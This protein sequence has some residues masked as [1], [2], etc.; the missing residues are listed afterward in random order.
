MTAVDQRLQPVL[1]LINAEDY[2]SAIADLDVLL[3]LPSPPTETVRLMALSGAL[4]DLKIALE[5]ARNKETTSAKYTSSVSALI[6]TLDRVRDTLSLRDLKGAESGLNKRLLDS[7]LLLAEYLW[8]RQ[9]YALLSRWLS[10]LRNTFP[11]HPRVA[12]ECA[13]Y[14]KLLADQ[15]EASTLLDQ[16]QDQLQVLNL[17]AARDLLDKVRK[18]DLRGRSL[19]AELVEALHRQQRGES[20][21][22]DVPLVREVLDLCRTSLV[23]RLAVLQDSVAERSRL[24]DL[25]RQ[26]EAQGNFAAARQYLTALHTGWPESGQA[27]DD[28]LK[29]LENRQMAAERDA[30]HVKHIKKQLAMAE[31]NGDFGPVEIYIASNPGKTDKG[32]QEIADLRSH[33]SRAK[34]TYE[35][36]RR[37]ER[38]GDRKR[39]AEELLAQ[40]RIGGDFQSLFAYLESEGQAE[41]PA[42]KRKLDQ[43]RHQAVLEQQNIQDKLRA[44]KERQEAE[45]WAAE[46]RG[47]LQADPARALNLA[48]RVTQRFPRDEGFKQLVREATEA[49]REK[50]AGEKRSAPQPTIVS[51]GVQPA[52]S[53]SAEAKQPVLDVPEA[54]RVLLQVFSDLFESENYIDAI[55]EL[56]RQWPRLS[57]P[58]QAR[59][60]LAQCEL[61]ND[62]KQALEAAKG[63]LYSDAVSGLIARVDDNRSWLRETRD[64][65]NVVARR[66]ASGGLLLAKRLLAHLDYLNTLRWLKSLYDALPYQPQVAEEYHACDRLVENVRL[67]FLF[68]PPANSDEILTRISAVK[69]Q[70]D[71][72]S[73]IARQSPD[74]EIN[75]QR[76]TQELQNYRDILNERSERIGELRKQ[77]DTSLA[78]GQFRQARNALNDLLYLSG[79]GNPERNLPG[80]KPED[81]DRLQLGFLKVNVEEIQAKL[82]EARDLTTIAEQA[83]AKLDEA[84]GKLKVLDF[85]AAQGIIEEVRC[86]EL[87]GPALPTE[88]ALALNRQR[89]SMPQ[90]GDDVL[91]KEAEGLCRASF[92]ARLAAVDDKVTEAWRLADAATQAEGN[93]DFSQAR[94]CLNKLRAGW[95]ESG[96]AID[97]RL[98]ELAKHEAAAKRD[99]EHVRHVTKSLPKAEQSGKFDE[100]EAYVAQHPGATEKGQERLKGLLQKVRNA[101]QTYERAQTDKEDEA[102]KQHA[103]KLLEQCAQNGDL[104]PVFDYLDSSEGQAKTETVKAHLDRIRLQAIRE[105]Q[106]INTE[107]NV[108]NDRLNAEERALEARMNLQADP[109][110][111][112]EL[113][114]QAAKLSPKDATYRKLVLEAIEAKAKSDAEAKSRAV[115]QA[116]EER[117]AAEEKHRRQGQLAQLMHLSWEKLNRGMLDNAE[118]SLKDA[119]DL[120]PTKDERD[121]ALKATGITTAA[122]VEA[123]RRAR[124]A[125]ALQLAPS[126]T[127]AVDIPPAESDDPLMVLRSAIRTQRNVLTRIRTSMPAD[128]NASA[129]QVRQFLDAYLDH[130]DALALQHEID[131]AKTRES[132]QAAINAKEAEVM[133]CESDGQLDRAMQLLDELARDYVSLSYQVAWQARLTALDQVRR[134]DLEAARST[135]GGV[136]RAEAHTTYDVMEKCE[137]WVKDGVEALARAERIKKGEE[138]LKPQETLADVFEAAEQVL[139]AARLRMPGSS[140]VAEK[141]RQANRGARLERVRCQLSDT[142]VPLVE[143]NQY[144][145]LFQKLPEVEVPDT[146]EDAVSLRRQIRTKRNELEK[147]YQRVGEAV[148][149]AQGFQAQG[150]FANADELFGEA[151]TYFPEAVAQADEAHKSE[152]WRKVEGYL[153][154]NIKWKDALL[155]ADKAL[156]E[157]TGLD[158][159]NRILAQLEREVRRVLPDTEL[160]VFEEFLRDRKELAEAVGKMRQA[161]LDAEDLRKE[162]KYSEAWDKCRAASR[163]LLPAT[164]NA[165]LNAALSTLYGKL[166]AKRDEMHKCDVDAGEA[167]RKRDDA[168]ALLGQDSAGKDPQG[169]PRNGSNLTRAIELLQDAFNLD[170]EPKRK[171]LDE[172]RSEAVKHRDQFI[173]LRGWLEEARSEMVEGDKT[174]SMAT[175]QAARDTA[176]RVLD[177]SQATLNWLISAAQRDEATA[178][179]KQAEDRLQRGEQLQDTIE[180][181]K[182][183]LKEFRAEE[184]LKLLANAP[185]PTHPILEPV[186]RQ[187]QDLDARVRKVRQLWITAK[188]YK[189][190]GKLGDYYKFLKQIDSVPDGAQIYDVLQKRGTTPLP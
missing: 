114:R 158:E 172:A 117:R 181:V 32:R 189:E 143:V 139:G 175:W 107:N 51:H 171:E 112:L 45:E 108:A 162:R 99:A 27:V 5:D 31:Q 125:E 190:R 50:E 151:V 119:V 19:S 61:L 84:E 104:R 116:E 75:K 122:V 132:Y 136:S 33:V 167:D 109:A 64:D 86:M 124:T 56:R 88:K 65:E 85:A 98:D 87:R 39:H 182:V 15:E 123:L 97:Q 13:A 55:D 164:P 152:L 166:V 46:A 26:A 72:L 138:T 54:D 149:R 161:L 160:T 89:Q 163:L 130:E 159:S 146:Y 40:A 6:T 145:D 93:E 156:G 49:K 148:A 68:V 10:A 147:A 120:F 113:A 79:I 173:K 52:A 183:L 140:E 154:Q 37:R 24:A 77:A 69:E 29:D 30:E 102:R 14:E 137:S 11:Q 127:P 169:I 9:N 7:S 41:T 126:G 76:Q 96:E 174:S 63:K 128:A 177:E 42:G 150:N 58:N 131:A 28:W 115:Q 83:S 60:L 118:K 186:R 80:L 47:Y 36:A 59:R 73:E 157:I 103:E 185:D 3:Q 155:A 105:Q 180:K 44:D 22:G 170:P 25:A 165:E 23:A 82:K 144:D 53:V 62:L 188:G 92:V 178:L 141:W 4:R 111:A 133:K 57:S 66:L 101:R 134:G 179:H 48:N 71:R 70:L 1:D 95:P 168:M 12:N 142:T 135:L 78:Q 43:I 90:E 81:I 16:A 106:R 21:Q 91:A 121:E 176:Q 34:R 17:D 129:N 94:E 2:G 35:T 18:L 100:L 67:S 38:D 74:D 8:D 184:A 110:Q 20:Q 153:E 187:A